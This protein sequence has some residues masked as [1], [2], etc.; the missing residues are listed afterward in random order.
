MRTL[1]NE[2]SIQDSLESFSNLN[3]IQKKSDINFV[4]LKNIKPK[5]YNWK[6]T[7]NAPSPEVFEK[8]K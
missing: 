5:N 6:P 7:R 8:A 4:Y 1:Q 2:N 3:N